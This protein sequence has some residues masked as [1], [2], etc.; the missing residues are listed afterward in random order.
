M[1]FAYWLM[2]Y[3]KYLKYS[4]MFE[5][6]YCLTNKGLADLGKKIR[7]CPYNLDVSVVIF[8]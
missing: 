2:I 4:N 6:I 3:V 1:P 7:V 8:V 5:T